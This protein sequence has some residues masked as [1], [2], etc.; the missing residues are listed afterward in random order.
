[1]FFPQFNEIDDSRPYFVQGERVDGDVTHIYQSGCLMRLGEW[2]QQN[3]II[4]G[5][6]LLG[7]LL[8][9]V[10]FQLNVVFSFLS[11]NRE[12][13][14]GLNTLADCVIGITVM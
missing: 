3:S 14:N 10:W 13:R 11:L 12:N 5:G 6:V 9:Q 8:P 4:V 1:M 7:V 2:V